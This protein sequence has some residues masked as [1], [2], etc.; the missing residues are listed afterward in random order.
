MPA[1]GG[2]EVCSGPPGDSRSQARPSLG[3][4]NPSRPAP[5]AAR[6]PARGAPRMEEAAVGAVPR[7]APRLEA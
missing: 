6:R 4:G 5:S 2:R 7:L 3:V 1:W